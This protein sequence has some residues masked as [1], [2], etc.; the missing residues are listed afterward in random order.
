MFLSMVVAN[1]EI[2]NDK[3]CR[4]IAGHFDDHVDAAV[5]CRAHCPMVHTPSFTRSHWMPPSGKCLRRI[6]PLAAT[7]GKFV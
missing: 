7:V 2:N 1:K 6:A 5:Q 4:Q 3:K